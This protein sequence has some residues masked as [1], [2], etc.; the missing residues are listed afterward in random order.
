MLVGVLAASM[1]SLGASAVSHAAL[2]IRNLYRPWVPGRRD[3]HYLF[4]G[5]IVIAV[6]L[7]GG[8]VVA[9]VADNLLGLF[10][11]SPSSRGSP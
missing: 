5:R 4:V 1:S 10:Q 11:K 9:L 2:V 7:V 3:A 6:T 8:I